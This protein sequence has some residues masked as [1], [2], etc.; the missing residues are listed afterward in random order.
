MEELVCCECGVHVGYIS[1][2]DPIGFV[3]CDDCYLDLQDEEEK[4]QID[5][6]NKE[7]EIEESSSGKEIHSPN[8]Y[9][10]ISEIKKKHYL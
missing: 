7:V 8:I 4:T 10:I 1:G 6:I 5:D 2:H 9:E 3:Y